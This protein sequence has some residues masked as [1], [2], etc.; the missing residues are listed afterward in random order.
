MRISGLLGAAVAL[1]M[2]AP[3]APAR[4]DI[5]SSDLMYTDLFRW[6][7]QDG[8]PTWREILAK[9]DCTEELTFYL[10]NVPS[11]PSPIV[12]PPTPV[13]DPVAAAASGGLVDPSDPTRASDGGAPAV[14]FDTIGS[15]SDGAPTAAAAVPEAS[16]WA[17]LLLGFS[18]LGYAA[19]RRRKAPR[20]LFVT[21]ETSA[22]V[23]QTASPPRP[24]T[25][26]RRA[27]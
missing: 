24:T 27:T 13:I 10:W 15:P 25:R 12:I 5:S 9:F 16:T 26:N 11:P 22:F 1:S 20:D 6:Q 19:V 23:R 8:T 17:M 4:A 7:G 21:N 14:P 2:L 3:I 18:G